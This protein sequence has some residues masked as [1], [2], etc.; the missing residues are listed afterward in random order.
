VDPYRTGRH[1][2]AGSIASGDGQGAGTTLPAIL[3]EELGADW[4]RVRL[5]Q[6]G[7]DPAYRNPRVNWQF[8][9]NSESTTGFFELLRRMGASAREMLIQVATERWRVPPGEC[10]AEDGCVAHTSTGRKLRFGELAEAASHLKPPADLPLKQPSEWKLLGRSLGRV[11]IP[12]KLAGSAVFGLDFRLPGMVYAAI[13]MPPT[14]GG[15]VKRHDRTPAV[16]MPGVVDV[17]E[18]PDAI[19]VVADTYWRARKA[20]AATPI[21]FDAGPMP[22]SIQRP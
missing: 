10:V 6:A 20:L 21:E 8:T 1:S 3:A 22:R 15:K 16:S 11:E 17:V 9:G 19:A 2:D 4:K 5:E 18:L 14:V 13:A 7:V 12:A